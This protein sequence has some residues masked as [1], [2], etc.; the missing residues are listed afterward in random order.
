MPWAGDSRV[1]QLVCPFLI[2]KF[3]CRWY[4]GGLL[5]VFWLINCHPNRLIRNGSSEIVLDSEALQ[6]LKSNRSSFRPAQT[7]SKLLDSQKT[8]SKS[9]RVRSFWVH[10]DAWCKLRNFWKTQTWKFI[11]LL[12]SKKNFDNFSNTL[13]G[14]Q[15]N[16][17]LEREIINKR[18]L[19][20]GGPNIRL[21]ASDREIGW[22]AL[23]TY[24][25]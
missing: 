4:F 18:P 20:I 25:Q 16:F 2:R 19:T 15:E 17:H 14:K 11:F 1:S 10:P 23:I 12:F 22:I 8:I 6:N 21:Y 5:W 24:L 13:K 3:E 7:R 9:P